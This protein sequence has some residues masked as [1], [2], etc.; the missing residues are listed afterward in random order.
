MKM[1]KEIM[2]KHSPLN[3]VSIVRL[4]AKAG[5]IIVLF[6]IVLLIGVWLFSRTARFQNLLKTSLQ[7][8]VS[9]G[10]S[11][12]ISWESLRISSL[13]SV[14]ISGLTLTTKNGQPV[15]TIDHAQGRIALLPLLKR[16]VVL[17]KVFLHHSTVTYNQRNHP[18][19]ADV[20]A[21]KTPPALDTMAP[22]WTF[23]ISAFVIDSLQAH[24][25]DS[26]GR[27]ANL[28]CA[29]ISGRLSAAAD[30]TL[31]SIGSSLRLT[32]PG[33]VLSLDTLY[34]SM[35][36]GALG[37][38]CDGV[39]MKSAHVT[40]RG[41]FTIPSENSGPIQADVVVRADNSF[42][43][44]INARAWGLDKC[45]ML[46]FS[47]R[48]RGQME[49]P[50]FNANAEITNAIFKN[51]A[52]AH[53]TISLTGD[54][55]GKA[56]GRVSLVDPALSGA[57]NFST[58]IS[59]LFSKPVLDEYYVNGDIIIPDIHGLNHVFLKMD[60]PVLIQKG[61]A[62]LTVNAS[63]AS[64]KQLPYA[65]DCTL[66]LAGMAFSNGKSL[67]AAGLKADIAH[68]SF[69]VKG[70][71]PEVLSVNADGSLSRE[72][73]SGS[74]T[75]D[76]INARP[77]SVL[78]INKD[79]SGAIKGNFSMKKILS[80]P[81]ANVQLLGTGIT[82]EGLVFDNLKTDCSYDKKTGITINAA[83]ADLHGPL[84]GA[85]KNIGKPG[86][87]GYVKASLTAHGP[88]LYPNAMAHVTIDT[89]VS[90]IPVADLIK[91][92][93][94]LHDSVIAFNDLKITKGL[95]VI[96]G[97]GSFDRAGKN[98]VAELSISSGVK[99]SASG[100]L[101]IKA[102]LADSGVRDGICTA[103]DVPVDVAHAWFPLLLIPSAKLSMQTAF[104]GRFSNPSVT[105]GLQLSEIAFVKT[106]QRPAIHAKARLADHQAMVLC[107]LSVGDACGPLL[108]SAHAA[109]MP[110]FRIDSLAPLP[111][112]IRVFGSN[113]CLKPYVEAFSENMVLDG[114][115]NAD[116]AF[117]FRHNRWVPE[118][119]ISVVSNKLAFPALNVDAENISLRM[120]PR[121]NAALSGTGPIDIS[122]QTGNVHYAGIASPKASV[123]AAFTD[124]AVVIDTANISF[125]KGKLSI[126]GNIP[127]VS[128]SKLLTR[129]DIHL[130]F[131][132]DS[133][134]A[135]VINPFISGGRFTSGTI[136]GQVILSPGPSKI[137]P[138]G[139]LVAQGVVFAV[140]DVSPSIGPLRIEVKIA[141][142][143]VLVNG[144]GLW[145]KGTIAETGF[146]TVSN[147][148]LAQCRAALVCKNLKLNYLDD[149]QVR[150]DSIGAVLSNQFGKWGLDG[151][152]LLG[153]SNIAYDVPFN[154]PITA[155]VKTSVSKKPSLG[156]NVQLKIPNTLTTNLKVGNV[157]TGSASDIR[158]SVAGTLLVT[159][160][161]DNPKFA[162][163]VQIDSGAATY[164]SHVFAIKHGYARLT[165]GSDINPFIDVIATTSL[166]QVQTTYGTDSIVVTLHI[167]GDVKNPA[168]ALTSNKGFSQ[169]EIISL[170]TFGATSVSLAGAGTNVPGSII[171]NSLSTVVSRQAQK[172]LGLEQVQF[173]GNL[174]TSGSNQANASVSVSK[175]I[176]PDVTVSYS[177]GIADTIS[178]Q[179]VISWKLKPFLFLEFES[180]D[181][182]N[183][184]I[185]LKY[186]I[187][188]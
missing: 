78:L 37:F 53:A 128:L 186:R 55:S 133:I 146:V 1:K 9:S 19:L 167:S 115:L 145:G 20:F 126:A 26:A 143:S 51:M 131:G 185:D 154:Q 47:S 45:D 135:A 72:N 81:S 105:A 44:G 101:A 181:K 54:P 13:S 85:L 121:G 156:L 129:R 134:G 67:P 149:T 173:Q 147:N 70:E 176:S 155:H 183:A 82:W 38:T 142:D 118:G 28:S 39:L 179:G 161:V 98:L 79:I 74:G 164:L 60:P 117:F 122:L 17:P 113:V 187:K 14:D 35:R 68:D 88:A 153:E 103:T 29:S 23:S 119:A 93:I 73:G 63:G 91:A 182:G 132:A 160:T 124:N 86:M 62:R 65:A 25:L 3:R 18:N 80:A 152:A 172:T 24:Y 61:V 138:E 166:S 21:P 175:K 6:F 90:N 178:Q 59:R 16:H 139:S 140:D 27:S 177:R 111:L 162:G 95:A 163:Q 22:L 50:T 158:T 123:Q 10:I 33:H 71:W 42:F 15:I 102:A 127:L 97:S 57:L 174:F 92:T 46:N 4:A 5:G 87:R 188:K 7:Q 108:I 114:A 171:S 69:S 130:T 112:E 157:L 84:T 66:G 106:S 120:K 150:L 165:G 48:L 30:F 144:G 31:N 159:G 49:H 2:Q 170:L 107:T 180:N 40:A 137:A 8:S 32:I 43:K 12:G 104:N 109:L 52:M 110:S 58:R 96:G 151:Y 168:I 77:L 41:S 148:S 89:L 83:S 76:I 94:T 184:G 11:G 75:L 100:T 34:Y 169:L 64:F 99:G 136:N 116:G 56:V 125:E 141:G 36:S